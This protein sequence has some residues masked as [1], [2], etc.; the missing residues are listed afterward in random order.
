MSRVSVNRHMHPESSINLKADVFC[1]EEKL[2][3]SSTISFCTLVIFVYTPSGQPVVRHLN[4]CRKEKGR[5]TRSVKMSVGTGR[6]VAPMAM[7]YAC[8]DD[9][10]PFHLRSSSHSCQTRALYSAFLCVATV[11]NLVWGLTPSFPL[12]VARF[13]STNCE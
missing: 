1:P 3:W 12:P 7:F 11:P 13:G 4:Q 2:T 10:A 8:I 9:F 5:A 6:W